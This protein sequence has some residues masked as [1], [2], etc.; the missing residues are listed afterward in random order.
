[1]RIPSKI[2]INLSKI[3]FVIILF[4]FSLCIE[5]YEFEIKNDSP[6]L[7]VEAQISNLSHDESLQLP[8]DGRFFQV[9]LRLSSDVDNVRDQVVSGAVIYIQDDLGNEWFY[10]EVEPGV[11]LLLDA[12]FEALIDI[13]YQ[14]KILLKNGEE[15]E[16]TWQAL[17][18]DVDEQIGAISFKE[19]VK[20]KYKYIAGEQEISDVKGI[21]VYIGLQQ[22]DGNLP[23]YY[24]WE[25]KPIWVYQ[26]PFASSLDPGHKCWITNKN[27]LSEYILH[28]D[29]VGG[30]TQKL[31]FIETKDNER[32]YKDFS[33]LVSQYS[34]SE[35]YFYFWE[36]LKEQSQKG[37]LFDSPPVNLQTNIK[38]TN[39]SK[40]VI[41]YFG[42]VSEKATRWNFNKDELS[43]NVVDRTQELCSISY[44]PDGPG[45]P[46]C[47]D[48]RQHIIGEAN[49]QKP[50]WWDYR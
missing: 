36:E 24:K 23:I 44:G 30:Y 34:M 5:P 25:F 37:G 31:A 33:L 1:M 2:N 4:S 14:L 27:Y 16:S 32:I 7:V 45:G 41:G 43:Y 13:K 49:N 17:P 42:V 26:S 9:N 15:Y 6:A 47:Y 39:S 48:C 28:K 20:Q 22:I 50:F 40:R 38:A 8:S 35:D 18:E 3:G 11:Y 10:D 21:D 19:E 29:N 12:Q 46:E